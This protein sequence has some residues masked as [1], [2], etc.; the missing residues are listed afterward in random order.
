MAVINRS[1]A[2]H[3]RVHTNSCTVSAN[4]NKDVSDAKI[5]SMFVYLTTSAYLVRI[6]ADYV[7]QTALWRQWSP[8]QQIASRW[9]FITL[10]YFGGGSTHLGARCD[11]L[12]L[13]R[14]LIEGRRQS[15]TV[16]WSRDATARRRSNLLMSNFGMHRIAARRRR[17]PWFMCRIRADGRTGG[18][19][20]LS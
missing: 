12:I 20:Y 16:A 18:A 5:E 15:S 3:R 6:M 14:V 11:N 9:L 2:N 4:G 17:L 8:V 7:C 10:P 1:N 19:L 13:T